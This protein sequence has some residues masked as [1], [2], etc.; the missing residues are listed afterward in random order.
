MQPRHDKFEDVDA[1]EVPRESDE[2][3]RHELFIANKRISKFNRPFDAVGVKHVD[4]SVDVD[5]ANEGAVWCANHDSR[6]WGRGWM[7]CERH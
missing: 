2:H 4:L 6:R 3:S 1:I 5:S 7:R